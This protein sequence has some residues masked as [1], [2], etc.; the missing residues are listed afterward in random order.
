MGE[1]VD[2]AA[3]L[4]LTVH[5]LSLYSAEERPGMADRLAGSVQ[6]FMTLLA[7][8]GW[9][10]TTVPPLSGLVKGGGGERLLP[11]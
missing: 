9:S 5:D 7:E 6:S 8:L 1:R 2:C 4:C 11:L 3:F 10:E